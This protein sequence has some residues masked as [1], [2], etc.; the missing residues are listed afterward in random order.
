MKL[1]ER[2]QHVAQSYTIGMSMR[3]REMSEQGRDVLNLS[4]G[5]PDFQVPERA[6][7]AAVQALELDLTKYDKVPGVLELREVICEKLKRENRLD[8]TP[9]QIVVSNGAKQAI[10]NGLLAVMN[11]GDEVMLPVPY[12]TSYPE[13]IKLCGGQPL[14]VMPRDRENYRVTPKDLEAAMG[15]KTRILIFN[16]PSNP[17]GTVYAREEVQAIGDFCRE[18]D[19][20]ILSDEIY[21]RFCYVEPCVSVASLGP[22]LKERTIVINGLSKS[23]AMT[24]LR[25]GYTASCREI[26]SAISKMQGHLT[27]HTSTLSQWVG[28][29]A[30]KYCREEINAQIDIYRK[31]REFMMKRLDAIEG[32]TY[33][34][35]DGAFYIMVNFG[36]FKDRISYAD[37]FSLALCERILEETAVA[38]VPGIAF[39][40]DDYARVS[41]TLEE[42]ELE[43]G[44]DRIEKFLRSLK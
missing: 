15:E 7:Q 20:W 27:S 17:A 29:S 37:S 22:E 40:L 38:I 8:Y 44:L 16:N 42:N 43:E 1:A 10:M 36:A 12:W 4:V 18:H 41:Y 30:L 26:A 13:I 6:K 9:D 3:A 31:R 21:E 25:V 14:P 35:P 32:L 39:G 19:I 2:T 28:H 5:E 24:G 23:V 34:K 33:L 11:P